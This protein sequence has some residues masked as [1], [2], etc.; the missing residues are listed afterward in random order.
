LH[1]DLF[2]PKKLHDPPHQ[3]PLLPQQS[4]PQTTA[5]SSNTHFFGPLHMLP[6]W[7]VLLNWSLCHWRYPPLCVCVSLSL[8]RARAPERASERAFWLAQ[9]APFVC[10]RESCQDIFV[11]LLTGAAGWPYWPAW[12]VSQL[13]PINYLQYF[14]IYTLILYFN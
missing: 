6:I 8:S 3:P 7:S 10:E 14:Y 11:S 5:T 12:S 4:L 9:S 2:S 13:T 1:P